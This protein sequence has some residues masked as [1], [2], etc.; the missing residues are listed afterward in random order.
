MHGKTM[1]EYGSIFLVCR[2]EIKEMIPFG[3]PGISGRTI[4]K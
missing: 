1:K 2:L 3:Y 4:L